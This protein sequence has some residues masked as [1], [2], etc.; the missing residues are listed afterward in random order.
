M[1]LL[2]TSI[3]SPNLSFPECKCEDVSKQAVRHACGLSR[4]PTSFSTPIPQ[5]S[6]VCNLGQQGDVLHCR[7]EEGVIA[8]WDRHTSQEVQKEDL[9]SKILPKKKLNIPYFYFSNHKITQLFR[10]GKT[11]KIV[12]S[13]H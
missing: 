12:K 9:P 13:N 4:V 7:G 1:K 5:L 6:S 10:L 8:D 3:I 11:F 2:D